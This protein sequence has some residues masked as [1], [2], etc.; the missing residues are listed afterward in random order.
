MFP[1]FDDSVVTINFDAS[2]DEL[3]LMASPLS[4]PHYENSHDKNDDTWKEMVE[5]AFSE[6]NRKMRANYT[7]NGSQIMLHSYLSTHKT[8]RLHAKMRSKQKPRIW[9]IT[10]MKFTVLLWKKIR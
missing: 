7:K 4:K 6:E 5:M 8:C 2:D 10:S 3:Q 9:I 1:E